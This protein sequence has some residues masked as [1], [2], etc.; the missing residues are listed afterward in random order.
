MQKL[1]RGVK[2]F[3]QN[4]FQKQ[5]NLFQGL[6][7]G[8]KPEV[9]FITCSDSRLDPT[10]LTQSKPG[11]VFIMRNAGN[12][13][14]PYGPQH[15]GESGTIE[16]AIA[17]L[18]IRDIIICGHSHCGAMK[19]VLQPEIVQTMPAVA[20]WLKHADATQ[21]IMSD[22]YNHLEGDNLL[23]A[24]IQ[25]NVLVQV[26]NIKTHPIVISRLSSGDLTIHAWVYKF[27][28]G[29]VFCYDQG[30]GQFVPLTESRMPAVVSRRRVMNVME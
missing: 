16:F 3:Q 23:N 25:E 27:E 13:I 7:E 29:E 14:P 5:K 24:A 9:L 2:H 26:E 28:T 18:G 21:K 30:E 20:G 12:I 22:N 17:A 19:G 6:A 10:M 4:I 15:T 11:E 8:Q 1:V